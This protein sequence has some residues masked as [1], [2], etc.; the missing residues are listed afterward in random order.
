MV[1]PGCLRAVSSASECGVIQ[2]YAPCRG[3][4]YIGRRTVTCD[5]KIFSCGFL[6]CTIHNM[7]GPNHTPLKT[8]C[9][10]LRKPWDEN[11][12][13]NK[14]PH[15]CRRSPCTGCAAARALPVLAEAAAAA[16]LAPTAAAA[17]DGARARRSLLRAPL[18]LKPIVAAPALSFFSPQ[19]SNS[20]KA[21]H[22]R[23]EALSVRRCAQGAPTLAR[24]ARRIDMR[25]FNSICTHTVAGA[26]R[27]HAAPDAVSQVS[28]TLWQPEPRGRVSCRVHSH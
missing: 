26:T 25:I 21:S 7:S 16:V 24:P 8:T 1:H 11:T 5:Q 14:R 27:S 22:A 28:T 15:N 19:Q 9:H 18:P 20:A 6:C 2:P 12:L 3:G 17:R 10:R 23:C 13:L 4:C